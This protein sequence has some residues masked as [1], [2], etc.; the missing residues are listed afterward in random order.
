MP[1]DVSNVVKVVV[2]VLLLCFVDVIELED[3][4][5]LWE[6]TVSVLLLL[7]LEVGVTEVSV[8]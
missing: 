3:G 2:V 4:V 1:D 7:L 8:G 6:S 5:E